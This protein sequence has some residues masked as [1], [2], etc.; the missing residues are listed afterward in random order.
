MKTLEPPRRS[1]FRRIKDWFLGEPG[2]PAELEPVSY[3]P[4][5]ERSPLVALSRGDVY[6][7]QVSLDTEWTADKMPYDTLI[8]QA[9]K[10]RTSADDTHRRRI[11]QIARSYGPHQA[12]E[13]EDAIQRALGTMCYDT[14]DGQVRCTTYFRVTPDG[15]VR[16]HLTPYLLREIDVDR[17]AVLAR[18][19]VESVREITTRWSELLTD[20]GVSPVQLSS[21][22]LA[23]PAFAAELGRLA[24]DRRLTA[25]QL[26]EVLGE[27]AK[28][29]G[30]LGMYEFVELYASAIAAFQRQMEVQDSEF[31]RKVMDIEPAEPAR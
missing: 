2:Q 5:G 19:R 26:V 24:D 15:R 6:E 21:A 10:Y 27:A 20:L 25:R 9:D 16:E 22:A 23:D 4:A 12:A 17:E 7:F 30:Q 13:A 28:D 3:R 29:H 11:W 18:Q 14:E 1:L 8:K 31:I